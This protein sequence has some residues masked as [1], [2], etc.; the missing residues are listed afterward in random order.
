MSGDWYQRR[1]IMGVFL[2]LMIWAFSLGMIDLISEGELVFDTVMG[3]F[4]MILLGTLASATMCIVMGV[5]LG[6]FLFVL[7]LIS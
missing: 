5:F 1:F 4:I 7:I 2:I 3:T 6:N